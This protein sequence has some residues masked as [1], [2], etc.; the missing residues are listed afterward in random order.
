MHFRERDGDSG[1]SVDAVESLDEENSLLVHVRRQVEVTE[2]KMVCEA[3]RSYQ[4]T[5]LSLDQGQR[6]QPPPSRDMSVLPIG[7]LHRTTDSTKEVLVPLTFLHG[8]P[9][10]RQAKAKT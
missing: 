6:V 7:M 9:W 4:R 1:E 3:A 10:L 5:A 2:S 8:L